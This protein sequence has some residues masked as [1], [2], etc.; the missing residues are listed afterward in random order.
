MDKFRL[1]L[2]YKKQ[3]VG[4]YHNLWSINA[5]ILNPAIRRVK[6][7]NCLGV[8]KLT[9]NLFILRQIEAMTPIFINNFLIGMSNPDP[10][11]PRD[12]LLS[13]LRGSTKNK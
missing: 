13:C 9:S 10:E 8:S 3:T 12:R 7:E 5:D 2:T 11:F 6:G 4:E 1:F